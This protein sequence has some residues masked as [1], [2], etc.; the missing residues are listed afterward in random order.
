V[1]K[2]PQVALGVLTAIGGVVD[3]GNLVANPQ[4]GARFG[5]ALAWVIVLGIVGIIV[6]AEMAG[7]VAAVSKRPVLNLVRERLGA[8]MALFAL[9]ASF[10]ITFL[11]LA[12]ELAG[13]ALAIELAT[14]VN[15]LAWIP[16]VMVFVLVVLWRVGFETMERV[17]GILGLALVVTV[18]A[19]WRL[20]PD[21]GQLLSAS[22]HPVVPKGEGHATYWYFAIA[23][24]GS[25]MTP[26]Q[27]FFF[28]SGAVEEKWTPADLAVE[29]S[30]V[31]IGFPLGGAFALALMTLGALVLSP[32]NIRVDNLGQAV[33]PTAVAL[34]RIGL[35][36]V[37]VGVVAATLG[38]AFE[39]SLSC[40]Y[41]ISQYFGWF[42]GKAQRP[43]AAPRF[44]LVLIVSVFL[45]AV[46]GLTTVDPFRLTELAIVFGA[47]ALPLTFFPILVV[48]NDRAYMKDKANS[49]LSN[50]LGVLFLV[51]LLVVSGVTIP[52]LVI[53][54]LGS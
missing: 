30:N 6:Y 35:A 13:V 45:A 28:S 42:W 12:A 4:A 24:L 23:Q 43:R 8:R 48:A 16:L 32:H 27:V 2:L 21:W 20:G 17:F 26:Y 52:L 10:L 39:T 51:L 31:F 22:L 9:V 15:Y 50:V 40:A 41:T 18:I 47:A 11:T 46:L 19:V 34:G 36:F 33:L 3:I 53:T 5:M 14:S 38:A 1:N 54:K 49:P 29:K 7:R 37:I 25:V 44:Y